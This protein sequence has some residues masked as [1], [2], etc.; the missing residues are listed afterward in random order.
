MP[1]CRRCHRV[2]ATA[3]QRKLPTGGYACKDGFT[4]KNRVKVLKA[5][6]NGLDGPDGIA[7]MPGEGTPFKSPRTAREVKGQGCTN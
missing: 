6:W 7:V 2:T 5:T 1:E 4:C 3:E